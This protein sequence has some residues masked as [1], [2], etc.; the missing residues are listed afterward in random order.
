MSITFKEAKEFFTSW[1]MIPYEES[2]DPHILGDVKDGIPA[3]C[4]NKLVIEASS[5]HGREFSTFCFKQI[6]ATDGRY[7][8]PMKTWEELEESFQ[9]AFPNRK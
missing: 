4:F 9:K 1:G 2:Y 5:L 3:P 6:D 8:L 7:Y